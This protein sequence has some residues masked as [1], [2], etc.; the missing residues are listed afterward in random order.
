MRTSAGI[1]LDMRVR[2]S[3]RILVVDPDGR[4]LLFRFV[5]ERGA[6]AGTQFWATPGGG[7]DE[8]ET[9]EQAAIR[10][11]AEETGLTISHPGPQVAR[12][13]AVFRSPEGQ[14]IK[15]DERFFLV[16]TSEAELSR[17]GWTSPER[18]VMAEHRWWSLDEIRLTREQ[19]WPEDL[20]DL[21]SG[22]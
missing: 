22:A 2:P 5:F 8:G 6:L 3:A 12:R 9:F 17:E 18:E 19:I 15:A 10:E 1:G 16:K 4:V 11:L 20:A 14:T 21:I 13:E 7:V